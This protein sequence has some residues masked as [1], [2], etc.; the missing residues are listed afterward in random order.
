MKKIDIVIKQQ[1]GLKKGST[2]IPY[3]AHLQNGYSTLNDVF[4]VGGMDVTG[5]YPLGQL[6]QFNLM[7][8]REI[9]DEM[10]DYQQITSDSVMDGPLYVLV[11]YNYK[12]ANSDLDNQIVTK[13]LF[14]A[15]ASYWVIFDKDGSFIERRIVDQHDRNSTKET[16]SYLKQLGFK[17]LMEN[18]NV[19]HVKAIQSLVINPEDRDKSVNYARVEIWD[20]RDEYLDA[21]VNR[22]P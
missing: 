3:M 14:D 1:T 18:D 17:K 4:A 9:L 16:A 15:M 7:H 2:N 22:M 13:F 19:N 21:I 6:K 20:D 12:S 10:A 5:W 11:T 8:I